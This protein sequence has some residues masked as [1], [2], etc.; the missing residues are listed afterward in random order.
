MAKSFGYNPGFSMGW[1]LGWGDSR[2]T[3]GSCT[4][5]FIDKQQ[6]AA[7]VGVPLP[8]IDA[9]IEIGALEHYAG[10]N[11]ETLIDLDEIL[12]KGYAEEKLAAPSLEHVQRLLAKCHAA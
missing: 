4:M 5:P 1:R 3:K 7:V 6:A 2:T 12:D 8:W 9:M 10:L 11:N